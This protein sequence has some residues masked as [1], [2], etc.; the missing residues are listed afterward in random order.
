[1][2]NETLTALKQSIKHWEENRDEPIDADASGCACALCELFTRKSGSCD[3]CPVSEKTDL[4]SCMGSPW[5]RANNAHMDY[6]K[7]TLDNYTGIPSDIDKAKA[8]FKEAAQ[9]EIDF[10]KSL[11]PESGDN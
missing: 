5:M 9:N 10:L 1:M 3:G 6:L 11:L 7:V 8:A 4:D 2:N